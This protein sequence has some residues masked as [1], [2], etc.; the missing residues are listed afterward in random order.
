[1][2]KASKIV[3]GVVDGVVLQ[4][5]KRHV[6]GMISVMNLINEA[7]YTKMSI[8]GSEQT[9][10]WWRVGWRRAACEMEKK[11]TRRES[12]MNFK[13]IFMFKR[14]SDSKMEI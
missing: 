8:V 7:I 2:N 4:R 9:S 11:K 5:K 1:M 13:K 3:W 14:W 10:A 12:M 6:L